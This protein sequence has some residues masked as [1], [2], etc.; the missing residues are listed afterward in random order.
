MFLL[1][2]IVS[3]VRSKS[4]NSYVGF[5][6]ED[7]WVPI[8]DFGMTTGT[9]NF[10]FR[11]K[12]N[13]P[14][15]GDKTILKAQ[16]SIF[17][18]NDWVPTLS[19]QKCSEKMIDAIKSYD[20]LIPAN[21]EWSAEIVGKLTQRRKPQVWH[22]VISDCQNSLANAGVK[23][24]LQVVNPGNEHFSAEMIGVNKIYWF[25]L[26]LLVLALGKNSYEF[27]FK[28]KKFLLFEA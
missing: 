17:L 26:V 2:F 27:F 11:A 6:D 19:R 10:T 15:P 7:R 13:N 5:K 28:L 1:C 8:T 3:V 9:G 22:F 14:V 12:T 21:G 4:L 16:I 23:Y 24:E 18:S 20:V 25:V